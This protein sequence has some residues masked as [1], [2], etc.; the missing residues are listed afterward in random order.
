[1]YEVDLF[2]EEIIVN[3]GL[4]HNSSLVGWLVVLFYSVS[5]IFGSFNTESNFQQFI[6]V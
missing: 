3:E 4:F 1:M 2:I 5:T 6:F